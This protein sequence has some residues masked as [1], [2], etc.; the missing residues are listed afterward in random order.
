MERVLVAYYSRT[1][2]TEKMAELAAEGV[3]A[4]QAYGKALGRTIN[5]GS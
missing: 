5:C 4:C 3:K 2:M 1:G